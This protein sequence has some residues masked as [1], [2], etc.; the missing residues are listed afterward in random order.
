M[1]EM[2]S[3]KETFKMGVVASQR[4]N[5]SGLR[6]HRFLRRGAFISSLTS[7]EMRRGGFTPS[8]TVLRGEVRFT[9]DRNQL[10]KN[11]MFLKIYPFVKIDDVFSLH[12]WYNH[13]F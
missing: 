1:D 2:E 7:H 5:L 12:I 10:F 9:F 3:G 13:L 8:T 11:K 6:V 4:S